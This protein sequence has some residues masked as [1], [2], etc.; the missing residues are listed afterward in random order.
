[1]LSFVSGCTDNDGKAPQGQRGGVAGRQTMAQRRAR[2]GRSG[3]FRFDKDGKILDA[4]V[5]AGRDLD[6][7]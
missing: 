1:M 2:S 3:A 7:G 6:R 5:D 4:D